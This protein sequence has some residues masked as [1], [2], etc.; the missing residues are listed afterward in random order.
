MLNDST[1]Q[2]NFYL[3]EATAVSVG[4]SKVGILF[5]IV[6][7][8][9][10][11]KSDSSPKSDTEQRLMK[12]WTAF[13]EYASKNGA[14]LPFRRICNFVSPVRRFDGFAIRRLKMS[15]PFY[16]LGICNPQP[17]E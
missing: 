14:D 3:V 13:N 4:N 16:A 10:Y 9:P 8:P 5:D 12:F 17:S 2:C 11:G 15:Q 7:A 6:C 1:I